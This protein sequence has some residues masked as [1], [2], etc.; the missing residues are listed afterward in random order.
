MYKFGRYEYKNEYEW[1]WERR[2]RIVV[3]P[4]DFHRLP[5]DPRPFINFY[6]NK[7]YIEYK[8][9]KYL[10]ELRYLGE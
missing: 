1:Y 10:D 4:K 2:T 7:N 5:D 8:D 9:K 3:Y 6:I